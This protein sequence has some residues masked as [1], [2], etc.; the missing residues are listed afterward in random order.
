M[1][2]EYERTNARQWDE[3]LQNDTTSR[4]T[5][6]AQQQPQQHPPAPRVPSQSLQSSRPQLQ[7]ARDGYQRDGPHRPRHPQTNSGWQGAHPEKK[8]SCRVPI[9]SDENDHVRAMAKLAGQTPQLRADAEKRHRKQLQRQIYRLMPPSTQSFESIGTFR[10]PTNE[11]RPDEV[12][13]ANLEALDPIRMS[14]ECYITSSRDGSAFQVLGSMTGVQKALMSL[15]HTCFQLASRNIPP[16]RK[17]VSHWRTKEPCLYVHLGMEY[18]NP[19]PGVAASRSPRCDGFMSDVTDLEATKIR[20]NCCIEAIKAT[21]ADSLRKIHY[22]CAH[23]QFRIRLGTFT[24]VSWKGLGENEMWD[25]SEYEEM[26]AMPQFRG[27]VTEELGDTATENDALSNLQKGEKVLLPHDPMKSGLCEVRP[28]YSAD[29]VFKD[30]AGNLQLTM[31]WSRNEDLEGG[32]FQLVPN[33][34]NW[35]RLDRDTGK[36]T[37]M[38]DLI[39]T[40]LHTG[41]AWDF[42]IKTSHD[43]PPDR[44]PPELRKFA[45]GVKITVPPADDLPCIELTHSIGPIY[46]RRSAV[47]LY[48][49]KSTDYT[50]ELLHFQV[51]ERALSDPSN[52]DSTF[53]LRQPRW[54]LSVYRTDWDNQ[55]AQNERLKVSD[56]ATWNDDFEV[57]FP[58]EASFDQAG[59]EAGFN[60]LLQRLGEVE[61]VVKGWADDGEE[62]YD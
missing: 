34:E 18:S 40:D 13:G 36:A 52:S 31:S 32:G 6:A 23:I 62:Q 44:V 33:G 14:T 45:K 55:F 42:E 48:N 10:W 15:R 4:A 25:L 8:R 7:H 49:I 60:Q 17:C 20:E 51:K 12:L 46:M 39:M 5:H 30:E 57:W 61:K 26:T 58:Q 21:I 35:T 47:Y 56:K 29:F 16:I 1:E 11:C 54:S 22:L 3:S 19:E 37:D 53:K 38:V 43:V 9:P 27:R 2:E 41:S 24:L 59:S 28:T 50:V